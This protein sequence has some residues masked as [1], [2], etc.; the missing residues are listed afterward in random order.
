MMDSANAALT[1]IHLADFAAGGALPFLL[2]RGAS[3]VRNLDFDTHVEIPHAGIILRDPVDPA[4][5]AETLDA[6]PEPQFR[7]PILAGAAGQAF[8]TQQT[9]FTI[10]NIIRGPACATPCYLVPSGEEIAHALIDVLVNAA[11]C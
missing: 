5:L 11:E 3:L 2:L 7:S 8:E 4:E 10:D 6:A 1:P 9:E